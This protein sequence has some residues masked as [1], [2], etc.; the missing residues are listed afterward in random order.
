MKNDIKTTLKAWP[1]IALATIGLCF[2]TQKTAELLGFSLPDQQHVDVIRKYL[3]NMFSS[4]RY[5]YTC[6]SLLAQV[7]FILPFLEEL[8]FRWLIFKFPLRKILKRNP[9]AGTTKKCAIA[10]SVISSALF[11][12]AHY[13]TQPFPDSAFIALFYFGLAQS[14]L[15]IKT[16]RLLCIFLNHMLFNLTNVVL[17]LIVPA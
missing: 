17:V 11:S 3:L 5:F 1:V 10:L 16:D 14:Y 13:I 9:S 15:Y 7:L 4:K 12:A 8:L 2:L 6:L